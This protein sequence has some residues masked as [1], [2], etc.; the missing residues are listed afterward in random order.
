MK[1]SIAIC[2]DNLRD[3]QLME[4]KLRRL[5]AQLPQI[6]LRLNSYMHA[7]E[8][9]EAC[10]GDPGGMDLIFLDIIIGKRNGIDLAKLLRKL[11]VRAEIVLVST[12]PDYVFDGYDVKALNYLLKPVKMRD[13]ERVLMNYL[14]S[15]HGR[16]RALKIALNTHGQSYK[17]DC[18]RLAFA[19]S[20]KR[21]CILR[22][23]DGSHVELPL[24]IS[25]LASQIPEENLIIQPHQSFLVNLRCVASIRRYELVLENGSEIPVSKRRYQAMK[26]RFIS[27]LQEQGEL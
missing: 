10:V 26:H 6:E 27:Y 7:D 25:Q 12:S 21:H 14:D 1:L 9:L 18:T 15:Q 22:Y 24:T 5:F 8:F 2:D 3:V 4:E 17:L 20:Y 23:L 13:L 19:E 11:R 16:R